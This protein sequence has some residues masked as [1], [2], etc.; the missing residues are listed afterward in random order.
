MQTRE[1]IDAVIA[2][3]DGNDPVQKVKMLPYL[4]K[5]NDVPEDL[6][7]PT[8]FSSEGEIFYCVASILRFASFVRKIFIV[9][10]Q[11]NPN[12]DHFIQTN[13]PENTIPVE[14]VDHTI[15]FK[16]YE[17]IL[18]VFN[19]LSIETCLFRIP[20]LSENF[21]YFNDD[22]F[23]V[24]PIT[25]TDWFV[26]NQAVGYGYWSSVALVQ[27]LKFLKPQKNGHKSFGFKDSMINGAILLGLK[28]YFHIDHTPQPMKKSILENYFAE[29]PEKLIA[30]ID[31]KFRDDTQFNPQALFYMLA[32][33]AGKCFST[34]K[35]KLLYLKPVN[36]GKTYIDRKMRTF[37]NKPDI[38]F[39]CIGSI[40]LASK[41]DQTRLFTWL[42]TILNLKSD[43][44]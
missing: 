7:G 40:D 14:I 38:T 15:I 31:H 34:T 36:R 16:G 30:N 19:S 39:C 18:P 29:N 13:F 24:R 12:V 41:E 37:E 2:W 25:E 17:Q 32:L 3:V 28:S 21:V 43:I 42:K 6:A 44:L 35:N 8:R 1:P 23:L 5:F 20:D 22:F 10:D 26:D 4:S 11:Q 33:K 27:L 9:T